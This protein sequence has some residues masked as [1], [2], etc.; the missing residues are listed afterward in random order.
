MKNMGFVDAVKSVLVENYANF[1][2]RARRS[3]YWYFVLFNVL[4]NIVMLGLIFIGPQPE[5]SILSGLVGLAL[6]IPGLAVVVRRFHDIGKSGWN[7]AWVLLSIIP[8][9][10]LVVAILFLIWFCRDSQPGEN[11]WGANPKE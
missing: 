11:K 4:L 1:S 9:A 2:G 6:I 5:F 10:G 7:L 8:I 3:E